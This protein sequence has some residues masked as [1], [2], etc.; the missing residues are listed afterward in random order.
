MFLVLAS[1]KYPKLARAT[2]A[3]YL[4]IE[5]Q[6]HLKGWASNAGQ[7]F[8]PFISNQYE[9]GVK[10]DLGTFGATLSAFQITQP[11][12]IVNA[13]TN[14]LSI[15]G[16]QRNRGLELSMFGE[17]FPGFKPLGGITFLEGILMSTAAGV[18]NGKTAPGVP[19]VQMNLGFDWDTPFIKRFAVSARVIYTRLAYLDAANRQPVPAWTRVDLGARY[20]IVRADG[21]PVT[22]RADVINVG[23]N[24]YWTASGTL[25][26]SP[27]RTFML[28]LTADF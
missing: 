4:S 3:V 2:R 1:S 8:P 17:P 21:T 14:T 12:A 19:A 11:S 5:S 10:L 23:N 16:L 18:N 28:S 25:S 15:D 20:S 27:P 24:N 9:L 13:T 22:L 6:S 26:Q 7:V